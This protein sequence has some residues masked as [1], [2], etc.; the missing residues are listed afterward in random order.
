M[1]LYN[2]STVGEECYPPK[3]RS[4]PKGQLAPSWQL[5]SPSRPQEE[6]GQR[7]FETRQRGNS[8]KPSKSSRALHA[9]TLVPADGRFEHGH[10]MATVSKSK[11]SRRGPKHSM[12][13]TCFCSPGEQFQCPSLGIHLCALDFFFCE[14]GISNKTLAQ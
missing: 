9:G 10:H 3:K 5:H 12:H 14:Q 7:P 1:I 6:A 13:V 8:C 11:A 2:N 4:S